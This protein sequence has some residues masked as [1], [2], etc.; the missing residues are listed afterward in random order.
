MS[1][2]TPEMARW[3]S[4]ELQPHE[5]R[6]RAYLRGRFPDLQ[7]DLDDLV[8]ETYLRVYKAKQRGKQEI[9]AAYLYV[10]ARNAALDFFRRR[11]IVTIERVADLDQLDVVE[12]RPDAAEAAIHEQELEIL[13]QAIDALPERC[14]AVFLLR[15]YENVSHREIAAQLGMAENTVNAHLVAA[16]VKVRLYLKAHGVTRMETLQ[17]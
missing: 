15:R 4:T 17:P 5:P 3:F 10:V 1:P 9:G 7:S 8:Q 6:L 13:A 11:R 12:E 14:R 16:M 2:P